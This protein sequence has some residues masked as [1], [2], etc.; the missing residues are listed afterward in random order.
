MTNEIE[1][2][3]IPTNTYTQAIAEYRE[4]STLDAFLNSLDVKPRTVETYRKALNYFFL[5]LESEGIN[6]PKD[7]DIKA[8][9]SALT[10]R[11][12]SVST[13][14]S[15]LT[16]VRRYFGYLCSKG[17]YPNIAETIKNPKTSNLHK[18]DALS[19]TQAKD[20]LQTM[21]RET[22]TQKRD[23]AIVSLMIHTGLRTIE[24]ERANI[25]DMRTASGVP[26]LWVQGKG[27][28]SKDER[29]KITPS[30]KQAISEYLEAR[31]AQDGKLID[32]DPLFTSVSRRDYGE[33]IT[34]RSVSRICKTS[35][36]AAGLDDPRLT[37]HSFRHTAVTIPLSHGVPIRDVQQMARHASPITTERYAHDLANLEHTPQDKT[38]ELLSA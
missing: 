36:R 6:H 20:V 26:V 33:R 2:Q 18:K 24:I 32:S 38:E 1:L 8:Y 31:S 37:A 19:V 11:K 30:V 4:P 25:E 23:F 16:A 17:I 5:W 21:P 35:L 12:M 10:E 3:A 13:I 9:K 22:L 28:D 34:T 29:V 7:T 15:Y 14:A 27:R